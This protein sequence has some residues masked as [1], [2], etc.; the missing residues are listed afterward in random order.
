MFLN[1]IK[2]NTA[3]LSAT[4]NKRE[5]LEDRGEVFDHEIGSFKSVEKIGTIN[6]YHRPLKLHRIRAG[7]DRHQ[8]TILNDF[9]SECHAFR[10]VA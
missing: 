4:T 3:D 10:S 5:G 6:E 2:V 7:E 8:G 1:G 9:V